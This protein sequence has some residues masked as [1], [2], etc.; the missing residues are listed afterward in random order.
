[1]KKSIVILTCLSLFL[2]FPL[3]SEARGGFN[4][5]IT[6]IKDP[7]AMEAYAKEIQQP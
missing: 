4:G 6:A 7:K 3:V 5:I 2:N 1:M